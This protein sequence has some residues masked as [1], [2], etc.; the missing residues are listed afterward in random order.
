M[1]RCRTVLFSRA[2]VFAICLCTLLL[3][4]LYSGLTSGDEWGKLPVEAFQ[5]KRKET[6]KPFRQ[7]ETEMSCPTCGS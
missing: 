1:K 3:V 7:W 2:K 4:V 5:V 6:G